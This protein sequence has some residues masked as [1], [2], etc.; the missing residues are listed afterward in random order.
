[1]SVL[2]ARVM[3]VDDHAMLRHGIDVINLERLEVSGEAAKRE[4][5]AALKRCIVRYRLM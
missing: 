5:L 1:M 3:L 2:K 4:A